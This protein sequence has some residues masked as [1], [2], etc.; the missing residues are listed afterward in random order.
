LDDNDNYPSRELT[1][2]TK[3]SI[4]APKHGVFDQVTRNRIGFEMNDDGSGNRFIKKSSTVT[5]MQ[6]GGS[7]V[8]ETV[9]NWS[10]GEQETIIIT[11]DVD[12]FGREMSSRQTFSA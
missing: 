2:F 9:N 1:E 5:T 7:K 12:E 3:D 11:T 8:E 10:D 4:D 6:A